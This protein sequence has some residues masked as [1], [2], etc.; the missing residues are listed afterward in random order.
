M[1][2][3]AGPR[4]SAQDGQVHHTAED[5]RLPAETER[6]EGIAWSIQHVGLVWEMF[7]DCMRM[8]FT[9]KLLYMYYY[10]IILT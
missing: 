9:F 5:Y 7:K 3:A 8:V 6:Y 10:V 2:H 4:P 1:H